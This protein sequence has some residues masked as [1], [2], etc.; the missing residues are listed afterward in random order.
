MKQRSLFILLIIIGLAGIAAA[1][2]RTI[3]N[4]DLEKYRQERLRAEREYR[5]NYQRLG[6]PSPEE[7]DRRRDQS[8]VEM[9][10]LSERMRNERL[11]QEQIALQQQI[12]EQ[13]AAT[14]NNYLIVEGG[15]GQRQSP[16]YSSYGYGR[17]YRSPNRYRYRRTYSQPGYYAGGQFWPT[18]PA[19][20]PRPLFIRPQSHRR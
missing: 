11:Q 17:V 19:T 1:Q 16:Y 14:N 15:N 8:F 13:Q 6:L 3:T 2:A 9:K 10:N 4:I 7:L 18:G 5:E 20:R 12:L